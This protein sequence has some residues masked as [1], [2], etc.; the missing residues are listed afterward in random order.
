MNN[1]PKYKA[2][3]PC[4]FTGELYQTFEEKIIPILYSFL[5]KTEVEGILLN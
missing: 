4:G 1:I 5:Q 2:P 3:G